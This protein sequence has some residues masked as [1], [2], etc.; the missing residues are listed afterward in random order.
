MRGADL[1]LLFPNEP[2]SNVISADGGSKTKPLYRNCYFFIESN[3]QSQGG[4]LNTQFEKTHASKGWKQKR[5]G[6]L[7]PTGVALRLEREPDPPGGGLLKHR[8][9]GTTPR[10]PG[11]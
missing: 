3:A 6:S 7:F 10:P 4:T 9:L 8:L 11:F 1:I 2:R 5:M